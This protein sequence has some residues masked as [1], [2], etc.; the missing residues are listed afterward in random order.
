MWHRNTDDAS[1]NTK[2]ASTSPSAP[3]RSHQ[4]GS[5]V[6]SVPG[7]WIRS[8][9]R[10]VQLPAAQPVSPG[11]VSFDIVV[12][13]GDGL[14]DTW[15]PRKGSEL[16]FFLRVRTYSSIQEAQQQ[17]LLSESRVGELAESRA[18]VILPFVVQ[19]LILLMLFF[20][21]RLCVRTKQPIV[22]SD[23]IQSLSSNMI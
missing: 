3:P 10:G 16:S 21:F 23:R 4:H 19:I 22:T 18:S 6:V 2:L 12:L 1:P 14:W 15:D 8:R 17:S 5:S 9:V 11:I 20:S 7:C 13:P